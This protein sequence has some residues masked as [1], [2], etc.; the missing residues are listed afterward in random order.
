MFHFKAKLSKK[1][2]TKIEILISE[3]SDYYRDF[4]FTRNNNRI[5]IKKDSK[6]LFDSLKKGEKI[7]YNEEG[8]LVTAGFSD[9]VY[10]K[11]IKILAKDKNIANK[12]VKMFFWN[13][14]TEIYAKLKKDNPLIRVLLDNNFKFFGSRGK[15]ILL[16]KERKEIKY[17]NKDNKQNQSINRRRS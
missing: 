9:K 15:E 1:D 5:F 16:K 10:R 11:Y 4:Y 8:I 14:N 7:V 3:L 6:I 12:L 17:D 2:Q 13:I